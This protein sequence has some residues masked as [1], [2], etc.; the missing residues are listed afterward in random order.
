[1]RVPVF[2]ALMFFCLLSS[3]VMAQ[4]SIRVMT[5]GDF[6]GLILAN[7]P[8]AKQA[9]NLPVMA[10]REIRTA[11]GAFD[12]VLKS[13]YDE[14][15]F[16]S[17]NYWTTWQSKLQVPV[18]FGADIKI[19][20]DNNNGQFLDDNFLVPDGGL[21]YV[22][23]TLPLGQGLLIDQRRAA[24]RQAQI[25]ATMADAERVKLI[26]KLLLQAAKDYWDWAFTWNRYLLHLESL[27]LAQVR[28]SAIRE[29][30]LFG[31]LPAI[32]SL[33]AYIEVQNRE[34]I[35]TQSLL[36]YNNARLISETY[37]WNNESQPVVLDTTVYPVI[38]VSD[39]DTVSLAQLS[40]LREFAR[41]N[42][43]EIVKVGAKIDQLEIERRWAAE[44]LRPKLNLDYNFLRGG[45]E[46]WQDIDQGWNMNNNYKMGVNFSVPL[47][48]REERGK[49]GLT[50]LKIQQTTLDQLQLQRDIDIMVQTSWNELLAM[51]DQINVQA[52]QVVNAGLMLEG[53]QFRFGAGESSIFLINARENS[54]ISSR[55]K[56]VELRAKYAKS[57]AFL[58]WAAGSLTR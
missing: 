44:K 7:H 32:D 15:K 19:A 55:I 56:L 27:R 37:L 51:R 21:T 48:L 16:D 1:M 52:A 29:R 49:L 17:K 26:N 46:P 36:E 25:G 50:K 3:P 30:V 33:E 23:L 41:I 54:L 6:Y 13:D 58:Y 10:Q 57:K 4:D 39:V 47:F 43:P 5:L 11:R 8:F 22:G 38:D 18:W 12:P 20:Y 34:N 35:R 45:S 53:E 9:A 2:L 42:H 40:I 14:K 28:F 24:L 31:D